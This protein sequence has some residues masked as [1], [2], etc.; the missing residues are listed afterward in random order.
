MDPLRLD[1]AV[2]RRILLKIELGFA[3]ALVAA[4]I[5][6]GGGGSTPPVDTLLLSAVLIG[7]ATTVALYAILR[8]DLGLPTAAC[9]FAV[10]YNLLVVLVKFVLAPKGYYEVNQNVE[11]NG[12]T[13]DEPFIAATV[14]TT[15]FLLYVGVYYV[16]YRLF[17]A[18][19][20]HLLELD[21]PIRRPCIWLRSCSVS[22]TSEFRTRSGSWLRAAAATGCSPPPCSLS[23]SRE[24][25]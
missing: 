24:S 18:H 2:Q 3:L 10:G 25:T 8:F 15:I 1:P 20:E 14:A 19:V 7:L 13:L 4:K 21:E 23:S 11:L 5:V 6:P 17:R 22:R 16:V 9:L 12:P